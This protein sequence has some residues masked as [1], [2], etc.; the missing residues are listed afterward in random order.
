MEVKIVIT[1]NLHKTILDFITESQI[2]IGEYDDMK[3]CILKMIRAYYVFNMDRDRLRD[4]MEDITYMLCPEDDINKD[5]VSRG[6]EYEYSSEEED[7]EEEQEEQVEGAV[8][9]SIEDIG[10]ISDNE[11]VQ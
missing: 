1:D 6:L 9:Q 3:D 7:S 11:I 5:R 2:I 4:A 8:D 10:T